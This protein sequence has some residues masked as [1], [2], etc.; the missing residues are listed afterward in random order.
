MCSRTVRFAE[1]PEILEHRTS[2]DPDFRCSRCAAEYAGGALLHTQAPEEKADRGGL[3]RA[4]GAEHPQHL[5]PADFEIEPVQR[6][7]RPVPV[8]H[9]GETCEGMVLLGPSLHGVKVRGYGQGGFGEATAGQVSD[10]VEELTGLQRREPC[11][12]ERLDY[13]GL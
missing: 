1:M 3:A 6:D 4:V 2:P 10:A 7:N 13:P 11:F 12:H 8:R 9:A 5:A